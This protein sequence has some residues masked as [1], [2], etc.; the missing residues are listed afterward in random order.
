MTADLTTAMVAAGSE[1]HNGVTDWMHH[2]AE[3]LDEG[4]EREWLS[5]MVS[6][7]I[8]YQIPM[9]QTLRRAGGEAGF[10]TGGFHRDERYGSLLARIA[11]NESPSAWTEDPPPRTRRLITNLRVRDLGRLRWEARTN[12]LVYRT[13]GDQAQPT[14]LAGER[15]DTLVGEASALRLLRREVRLDVSVLPVPNLAYLF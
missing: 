5:T 1:I 9:R 8:V 7:D 13:R 2:E 15:L 11:R 4:R 14:L 12:L 3:L 6:P 10:A